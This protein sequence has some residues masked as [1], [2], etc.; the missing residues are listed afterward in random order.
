MREIKFRAWDIETRE[1]IYGH[2]FMVTFGGRVYCNYDVERLRRVPDGRLLLMQR[3]GLRDK[4]GKE[5]YEGDIVKA[6]RHVTDV[7]VVFVVAYDEFRGGYFKDTDDYLKPLVS[8][9]GKDNMQVIGNIHEH[10]E[11]LK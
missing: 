6:Y 11:L 8:D 3:T 7:Y 9:F 10:P 2:E 5:I 4:N 1:M